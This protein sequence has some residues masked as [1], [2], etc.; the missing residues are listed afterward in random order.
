MTGRWPRLV[1]AG[2]HQT[3][4]ALLKE[5]VEWYGNP[6]QDG[7][8]VEDRDLVEYNHGAV[9]VE[10]QQNLLRG[11]TKR[12]S[13][14]ARLAQDSGV[15]V[16]ATN[17][18]HYHAPER[19]RLQHALEAAKRNITIDQ[20]LP[21]LKPNHHLHLKSHTQMA[22]IL[23]DLPEAIANTVKIAEQCAFDLSTD[24]GYT[25]PDPAVPEGFTLIQYLRTLC[26]T[27]AVRRYGAITV[28]VKE[29]L[30][31]EFDLIEK[32]NLAGFLLLYREIVGIAQQ[33]MVER[34]LVDSETPLEERP[35][36]RGRG[37]S[38]ALLVGYLI[39]ISHVDPLKWNLTL[40]RFISAGHDHAARH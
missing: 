10:L 32:H 33:I 26:E 8:L 29:R 2:R 36:G 11:D 20:A 4:L 21:H 28:Q 38:V 1:E 9:Y 24:L 13:E 3:A 15:P 40:E 30:D 37:S 17:D 22:H 19:Y 18:V 27:A 6:G 34:G 7:D 5:Y 12:N 16:V 31:E 14:L 23:K 25:L 35:P 39:G